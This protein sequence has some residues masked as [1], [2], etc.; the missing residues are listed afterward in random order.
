[1]RTDV[2]IASIIASLLPDWLET[3]WYIFFAHQK[4]RHPIRAAGFWERAS[5]A[6]YRAENHFHAKARLPEGLMTQLVTV[7]FFVILLR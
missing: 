2:L 5:Y 3:P 6:I 1:V 7:F 4:K